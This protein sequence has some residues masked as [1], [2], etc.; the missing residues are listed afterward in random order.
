MI[1][2][3]KRIGIDGSLGC[4]M[5]NWGFILWDYIKKRERRQNNR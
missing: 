5:L 3:K 1:M 4:S 2:G